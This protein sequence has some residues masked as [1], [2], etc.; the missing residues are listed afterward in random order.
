MV[1]YQDGYNDDPE[2][3]VRNRDKVECLNDE[4]ESYE[5]AQIR[6]NQIKI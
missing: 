4:D 3:T 5:I 1:T 2:S 6:D